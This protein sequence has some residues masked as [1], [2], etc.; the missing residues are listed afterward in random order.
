MPHKVLTHEIPGST[1]HGPCESGDEIFGKE[2]DI[3]FCF[4]CE[5]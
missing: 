3:A 2:Y 1:K 4:A 5:F